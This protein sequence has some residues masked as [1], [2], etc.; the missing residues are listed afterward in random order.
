M[1]KVYLISESTIK[2][3]TPINDNIEGSY[4]KEA[5]TTAQDIYLQELIGTKLYHKI[6]DMVIDGSIA[7]N[8]DYKLLLDDYIQ[9]YLQ[10]SILSEIIIPLSF[11]YRNAG[12][13]QTN[14]GY[15]SNANMKDSQTIQQF[16]ANRSQFFANRLTKYLC[17]N[18]T[19]YPEYHCTDSCADFPAI[20]KQNT[21]PIY[22]G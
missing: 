11:K 8:P 18:S 6:C 3:E 19:K 14:T 13:I 21:N 12:L 4:I 10:F 20:N 5:I 1:S 2:D 22:L 9:P 7:T 16:Y 15:V 17:A